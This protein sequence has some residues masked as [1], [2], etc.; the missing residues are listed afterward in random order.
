MS[1]TH[2]YLLPIGDWGRDGHE[3]SDDFKIATNRTKDEITKAYLKTA[4][5]LNMAFDKSVEWLIDADTIV[6]INDY[7][8]NKLTPDV[9]KI[10]TDNGADMSDLGG[11]DD[12]MDDDQINPFVLDEPEDGAE[13]FLQFCKISDPELEWQF[14]RPVAEYLFGQFGDLNITVGYGLYDIQ[15]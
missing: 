6:L 13:L 14:E 15:D 12:F 10:L 7:Q 11:Y 3:R 5:R 8:D 2:H 9:V 4:S 1:L